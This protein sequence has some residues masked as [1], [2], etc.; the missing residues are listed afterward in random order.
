VALR[1]RC[2]SCS[3]ALPRSA[4]PG[5]RAAALAGP[6]GAPPQPLQRAVAGLSGDALV[7]VRAAVAAAKEGASPEAAAR[8]AL[9]SVLRDAPP[10]LDAPP[11]RPLQPPLDYGDGLW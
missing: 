11:P 1:R 4:A 7:R 6:A 3:A 9:L 8:A 5:H 2:S 10:D